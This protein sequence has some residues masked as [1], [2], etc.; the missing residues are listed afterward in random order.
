MTGSISGRMKDLETAIV[1]EGRQSSIAAESDVLEL[2][3]FIKLGLDGLLD[4]EVVYDVVQ[5]GGVAYHYSIINIVP[6]IPL[7]NIEQI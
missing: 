4:M 7:E 2:N 6:F 3:F 1:G 5:L